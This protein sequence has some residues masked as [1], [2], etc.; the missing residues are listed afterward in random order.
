M[1][2]VSGDKELLVMMSQRQEETDWRLRRYLWF[3]TIILAFTAG[4]EC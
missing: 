1:V 4:Q 3:L 2:T